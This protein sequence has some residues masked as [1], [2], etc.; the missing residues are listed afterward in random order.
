MDW[1]DDNQALDPGE[2]LSVDLTIENLWLDATNVSGT[3]IA[4]NGVT[5]NSSPVAFGDVPGLG[6]STARFDLAV[7]PGITEHRYVLFTLDLSA[8]SGYT[9]SRNFIAEIGRLETD[10]TVFESF[11]PRDVD[12]YDEFH[13]WHYDLT[14]LPAG[15]NQLVIETTAAADIDL[16]VKRGEPPRYN[17]TVGINPETDTGFFCTSGTAANCRDPNTL[18]SAGA[19][20]NEAVMIGNPLPGSYHI[21]IVNF[22]Q[23]QQG[24]NYS[25]RAYT[26]IAPVS[27]GG[28][29]GGSLGMGLLLLAGAAALRVCRNTPKGAL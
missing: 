4:S 28:G 3:L 11:A 13:A 6:S 12:L 24:L 16:L 15:H 1:V 23:L 14:A 29:G 9:A 17:I 27:S 5:V 19:D 21:V 25:L 10:Q 22:A 20:G 18:L 7:D 2:S 26:R 8:D